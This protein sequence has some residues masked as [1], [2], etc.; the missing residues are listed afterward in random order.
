MRFRNFF[1]PL[2][3]AKILE[4]NKDGSL[5]LSRNY[6]KLEIAIL[7]ADDFHDMPDRH[8]MIRC[9]VQNHARLTIPKRGIRS[10]ALGFL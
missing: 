4:Q 7:G 9:G 8:L 2:A 10:G 1:R 6:H 5:Q 3:F